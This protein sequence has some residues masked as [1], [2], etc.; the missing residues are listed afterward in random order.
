MSSIPSANVPQDWL[1][2]RNRALEAAA[3]RIQAQL[4]DEPRASTPAA[5][6]VPMEFIVSAAGARADGTAP[7]ASRGADR[8][9]CPGFRPGG[10]HSSRTATL[11]PGSASTPA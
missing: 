4:E 8:P 1:D 11:P 2:A 6:P 7:D 5:E 9:A 3:R 10:A